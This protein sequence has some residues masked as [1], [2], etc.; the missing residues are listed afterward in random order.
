M[1]EFDRPAA[2]RVSCIIL[3]AL[4]LLT[5]PVRSN[6]TAD[7]S[8]PGVGPQYGTTH[9]YVAAND[10]SQ[11]VAC[12]IATFGGTA[13]AQSVVTVTPTSSQTV[14]QAVTT[15]VGLI[16]V[17]GFKTPIPYPFGSERTGYLGSD[18]DRVVEAARRNGAA[19]VVAPFPDA[20]GKDAIIQ[21]P[22]GV[23]MQLYW[24][25]VTPHTAPLAT[26]PENRIYVSPDSENDFLR[27][28][29][30]FSRGSVQSD[31]ANAPG[32]EIGTSSKTY[33]RVR[34][35]SVFG[36]ITVLVTDGHLPYPYGRE[37]TGYDVSDLSET[38]R[39]ATSS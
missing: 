10:V 38:L 5:P 20:I 13:T 3:A 33:P 2:W 27:D 6:G 16:S 9:V 7:S 34:I 29:L 28:F 23:Y 1:K 19:L 35:R 12:F 31:E 21:W 37:T 24:H 26:V 11:L 4:C 36:N 8:L 15:P 32:I 14:W 30:I 18:F 39:K 22:G 25:T 17:F